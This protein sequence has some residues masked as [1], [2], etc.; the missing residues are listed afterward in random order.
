MPS[1]YPDPSPTL[2]GNVLSINRLVN[3]PPRTAR[4]LRTLAQQRLVSPFLFPNMIDVTGSGSLVYEVGE[5]IYAEDQAKIV[6][7]LADYPYTKT[8]PGTAAITKLVKQ[9]ERTQIAD[10]TIMTSRLNVVDR[11]T[12]KMTNTVFNQYDGICLSLAASAVTATQNAAATW[13]TAGAQPFADVMYA[14]AK[15]DELNVGFSIDT[16]FLSPT[17]WA[18]AIVSMQQAAQ[19]PR[20]AQNNPIL[21][22]QLAEFGGVRFVQTTNLPGGT[23]GLMVDSKQFGGQIYANLGGDWSGDPKDLQF[24]A[25]RLRRNDGWDLGIRFTKLPV[26]FEPA[27][28]IK[29]TGI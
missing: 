21:T 18:Q 13:G 28:S 8:V 11:N 1:V 7:P 20:D 19:L 24:Q 27:A 17:K 12:T 23:S 22:G 4:A 9:G 2:N 26:V 10:E 16:I 29:L 15:V 25:E 14:K 3:D 6:A 5:G